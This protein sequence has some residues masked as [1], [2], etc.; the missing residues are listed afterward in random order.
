MGPRLEEA[1]QFAIDEEI[2]KN[3]PGRDKYKDEFQALADL[4]YIEWDLSA[5]W[6]SARGL[7]YFDEKASRRFEIFVPTLLGAV[8]GGL[9]TL[10]GTFLAWRLALG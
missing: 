3:G 9:F 2:V 8:I 5:V 4:G 10:L 7:D 6:P 1:L